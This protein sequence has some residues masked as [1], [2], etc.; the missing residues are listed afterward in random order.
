MVLIFKCRLKKTPLVLAA[1]LLINWYL[2]LPQSSQ[3][4]ALEDSDGNLLFGVRVEAFGPPVSNGS[5]IGGKE[6]IGTVLTDGMYRKAGLENKWYVTKNFSDAYVQFAFDSPT[7]LNNLMFFAGRYSQISQNDENY[8]IHE[9]LNPNHIKIEYCNDEEITEAST[10]VSVPI[11]HYSE[12]VNAMIKAPVQ[13][14]SVYF[15]HI[16]ARRIRIWPGEGYAVGYEQKNF[17]IMEIAA[18]NKPYSNSLLYGKSATDFYPLSASP[19]FSLIDQY[20]DIGFSVIDTEASIGLFKIGDILTDGYISEHDSIHKW[21]VAKPGMLA[22]TPYVEYEL[23]GNQV[24][25]KICIVSGY[26]SGGRLN[27]IIDPDAVTISYLKNGKETWEI[28]NIFEHE[29]IS[30]DDYNY[31]IFYMDFIKPQKIRISIAR[32]IDSNNNGGFRI[33]E[34]EAYEDESKCDSF[35]ETSSG[36]LLA[37]VRVEAFGPPVSNGSDIGGKEEI[38][39]VLTDGMYR[40][41]GLENKWYVTKNFSDAYVQ[42]AFDSPTTLNN[43]M[44][45]AGRY[46]QISQNDENYYIHEILNPNHIKIEYCNDEEITEA[47]TWVS[48]PILHHSE[49]V[50]AM[51]KAPVQI[52]SVYFKHITAKRIRIWPGEGYAVG[53]EQKNFRIM[54][55][56]A[57]NKPYSNSLLYGKSATDFYPLSASPRYSLIAQYSDIGFSVT[58]TR[59][60]IGLFKIGDI[61]T[62]GYISEHDSI[63]KWCVAKPGMLAETPYVEYELDGNQ[64]LNK[65]CIVSGYQSGGRLNQIIDPDAV[66]ISYLKN[67]KETWEIANIFEH[68]TISYDDYNYDIFYMDFI[69]PQKIR[70]SIARGIDSNNNGGFRIREIEAYEDESKCDSFLE[71]SDGN[72]LF[73]VRVEAFGPPVSNGSDIGG[74]E[75]IGTVLTDGMYRKAGLENKW[76]VTKN[77]SDAYVQFAFDSPTTLNNLMFFAG[78]YSQISQNDENYYIHEILN[79]NHIKIEYCNDEEITEASTWVSVPILH[80]SE[81]VNAMIKAP[82]QILSV[83]FKHIT[84]K[85]IRIWPGEGYAVGREQKN[86]RI[87]EIAAYNKPYSNSLLYGKSATDFYPLSASPRYSLIAQYSDIGFSVTD[88]RASIG[89]FKIGDI[90]TDGYIS[91]HDSIHKWCVAK[92]GMLAETPYVEYELDGNQVLN[93]ICI[94]SGYQS[95]G[96]LNQIIDPDAVTISYLKNG[97]ETWEIANIFEHETISYDDYN[98]DIFY[99]DFIKPQK[100]R[101]SIARGID[102]NN[103]GGFRIREIEAYEDDRKFDS[104]VYMTKKEIIKKERTVILNAT[105]RNDYYNQDVELFGAVAVKD[106]NNMLIN[107]AVQDNLRLEVGKE[108]DIFVTLLSDVALQDGWNIESFI[109]KKT[110]QT[111]LR[112]IEQ[113][114]QHRIITVNDKRY[115]PETKEVLFNSEYNTVFV[116]SKMAEELLPVTQTQDYL[117]GSVTFTLDDHC[118]QFTAGQKYYIKNGQQINMDVAPY[119]EGSKIM[120]PIRDLVRSVGFKMSWD[121]KTSIIKIY[122]PV[123][124]LATGRGKSPYKVKIND[125][126][127]EV[128]VAC[129]ADFVQYQCPQDTVKVDVEYNGVIEKVDIRPVSKNIQYT[130]HEN[131]ITFY[132]SPGDRLSVEIN[133]DLNRPLLVF[134]S[135]P[136]ERPDE[137]DPNVVFLDREDVY[138]IDNILFRDGMIVYLG[139]NVVLF[140]TMR[141]VDN[142]DVKLIGTGIVFSRTGGPLTGYNS[143]KIYIQGPVFPQ[144]AGWHL[145]LYGCNDVVIKDFKEIASETGSDGINFIGTS[146]VLV[147]GYFVKN[148]DDGLCIKTR[149]GYEKAENIVMRNLVIWTMKGGNGIELGYEMNGWGRVGD[150]LC[151]NVDVIHRETK[152][153]KNWRAALSIHHSGNALVENVTY[154]NVRVEESDENFLCIGYFYNPSYYYDG[155]SPPT[156]VIIRN[157]TFQNVEYNGKN[158]VPSYFYNIM[159][160]HTGGVSYGL[161]TY[162][163]VD[164][165]DNYKITLENVVFDNVTYQGKQIKSLEDAKMCHFMFDPEVENEV[166]FR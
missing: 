33:R 156:G 16:T 71:A 146:N 37:G 119:Y 122:D 35:L 123:N 129:S 104:Y 143:N 127:Q 42:F 100:I 80:H 141:M 113:T 109:W 66:T 133:E 76:Y 128:F 105:V 126:A 70:I 45:F 160:K 10:W 43:L 75:E 116:S 161:G 166:E 124:L 135:E 157:I 41:A 73:G 137:N 98:Y 94:V 13:I 25:N 60:S 93:K 102:S 81:Q 52:L 3:V 21:C 20:S 49:Q 88:T 28:A 97:K 39:T 64:V 56:A 117:K 12:Q 147:D 55:I 118:V 6:E 99:M 121:E 47:S 77:F 153:T 69:K 67:G 154:K 130:V 84:A 107:I 152:N 83:Y 15:K 138:E 110:S 132:A 57:Y 74:K 86:F 17:R 18:Y 29:T 27:Q 61:L 89:L 115:N 8:Y 148:Q 72:L 91:E 68:E 78:R 59:A 30:Y 162:Y 5:D 112:L 4:A 79:P 1:C 114:G 142:Y 26:Q 139:H 108:M 22:E 120:I 149:K 54:E 51:I 9:I 90:L 2:C 44:F 48:V 131:V 150:I 38:G 163:D 159:R 145:P 155:D 103:N 50:N 62:D 14:L 63:H 165:P 158:S 46:S 101:I 11:L 19:K 92:P 106:S 53:R 7:T 164:N 136:I 96:R 65:I 23:D 82:V 58:D 40:K 151:E 87:M 134:L 31:D 34:I 140:S 32:G 144:P 95:G 85:R 125:E 24:L 36:N 111:P